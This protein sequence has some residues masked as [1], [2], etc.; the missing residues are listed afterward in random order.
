MFSCRATILERLAECRKLNEEYQRQFQKTKERLK[1][2]PNERQFEFRY[3]GVYLC[4]AMVG[5]F[6]LQSDF[7]IQVSWK[8]TKNG[9]EVHFLV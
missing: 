9:F 4:S 6:R 5:P 7:K 2:N 8:A 1:A 3:V